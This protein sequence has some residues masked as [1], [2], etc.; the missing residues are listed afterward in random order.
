V[1][2]IRIHFGRLDPNLHVLAV[3]VNTV[4]DVYQGLHLAHC[5]LLDLEQHYS[6]T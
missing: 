4:L 1:D 5:I 6:S 3:N 2:L